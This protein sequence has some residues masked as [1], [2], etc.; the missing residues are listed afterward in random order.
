MV[1][2]FLIRFCEWIMDR[3][4]YVPLTHIKWGYIIQMLV[5]GVFLI[6]GIIVARISDGWGYVIIIFIQ[7]GLTIISGS[8]LDN[9]LDKNLRIN[10]PTEFQAL[11]G[12]AGYSEIIRSARRQ[13]D[14]QTILCLRLRVVPMITTMIVTFIL[15]AVSGTL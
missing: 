9:L 3:V 14:R 1:P 15:I 4:P 7:A 11:Y 2:K 13:G 12:E 6:T 10:Y 5:Q 8:V